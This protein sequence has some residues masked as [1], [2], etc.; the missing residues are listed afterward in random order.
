MAT[1]TD[2]KVVQIGKFKGLNLT[3]SPVS[4][5][6]NELSDVVNY[7]LSG[8]GG[9]VKRTGFVTVHDDA[10]HG[11]ADLAA[12]VRLLGFFN[13]PVYQHF[14]GVAGGNFYTST[15]AITWTLAG[16]I[17]GQVHYGVQY[18]DK[19]LMVRRGSGGAGGIVEWNGTTLTAMASSPEGTFCKVFKDR[20]FV[21][22]SLS[23]TV[24]SRLYYSKPFD[25][26]ATGWPAT[27]F[28][29]VGAGDG[30]RLIACWNVQDILTVFKT[31]SSWN[32]YV[33][34]DPTLWILRS[35]NSEVGC[36]SKFSLVVSENTLFF[37]GI[38]GVYLTDGNTIREI[39]G[40][41]STMFDNVVVSESTI[42][43]SSAFLWEGKYVLSLETYPVTPIW[44]A[45]ST[46]TWN[47]L[48]T[49]PWVGG[50]AQYSYLVYH[51]KQKGWTKWSLASGMAPH[52]FV[53]VILSSTLKGL[54][55]GDRVRNGRVYKFGNDIYQDDGVN[56]EAAA[57]TKEFDFGSPTEMKR[58]KW[59]GVLQRG[60]GLHTFTHI[61]DGVPQASVSATPAV[62]NLE[63]KLK[64]PGYFRSWRLRSSAT[65]ANPL[66]LFGVSMHLHRRRQLAAMR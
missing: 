33:Q 14:V 64:G 6:D 25:Y 52:I 42:D 46:V 15:D 65:H 1:G 21:L 66:T 24:A 57:E 41:I 35:F 45:W 22:D 34:G 10:V 27:N 13:T 59:I 26:S 19:F 4:I 49:T 43:R 55:A 5:N 18:T 12:P 39:S 50:T 47:S 29:D 3:E 2:E 28:N 63:L 23:S 54:Y 31:A 16:A 51:L 11:G 36:I 56:Y 17:V 58:G 37:C 40:D 48:A 53:P 20:L 30:D 61:A 7:D 9:L 44:N 62:S 8:G 32:L 38:K 60:A